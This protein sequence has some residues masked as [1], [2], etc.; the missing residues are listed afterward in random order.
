MEKQKAEA[1]DLANQESVY[2]QALLRDL[3]SAE[4]CSALNTLKVISQPAP[5]W[6]LRM[7]SI[8]VHR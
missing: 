3:E 4:E 5:S 8:N 1:K 7:G 6:Q 2:F